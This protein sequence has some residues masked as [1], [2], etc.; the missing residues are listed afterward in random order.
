MPK[1][2][3]FQTTKSDRQL[4]VQLAG[5]IRSRQ[6]AEFDAL[7]VQKEIQQQ[8]N[9]PPRLSRLHRLLLLY[10]LYMLYTL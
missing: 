7:L 9:F 1:G 5:D 3:S 10:T 4:T 6:R 2:E 8:V